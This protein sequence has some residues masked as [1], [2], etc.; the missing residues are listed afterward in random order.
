MDNNNIALIALNPGRV[1]WFDPIT[2]IHLTIS[3]PE[4]YI[5]KGMN[6]KNIKKAVKAKILRVVWGNLSSQTFVTKTNLN[7]VKNDNNMQSIPVAKTTNLN[8]T[9]NIENVSTVNTASTEQIEN[10]TEEK[11][12]EKKSKKTKK[13]QNKEG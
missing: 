9:V 5:T 2:N 8:D 4:A 3:H 12:E 13:N 7:S 1:G 11:T 6:I 10:Q